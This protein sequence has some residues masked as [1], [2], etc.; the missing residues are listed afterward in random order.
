MITSDP[1]A[2]VVSAARNAQPKCVKLNGS[3]CVIAALLLAAMAARAAAS[4]PAP[5]VGDT[6]EITMIKESAQQGRNGSSGDS[7]D[8]DTIIERVIGLRADGLELEYDLPKDATADDR[9]GNWQFPARIFKPLRG[10]AQLLNSPE[11]EV[12]VDGWLKA[13]GLTRAACGHWIFTWNVFRIECD[14]QSVI[15]TVEAFDLRSADLREGAPYQD[16]GA[17]GPGTLARKATGPDGA[18][19]AVEMPVDPDAVRRVR[20][21]SDVVAGEILHKPVTLDAA[22]RAR[23]S[24]TVSGT[25]SVAFETDAAGSL[26][27]RTKVT[28]LDIK[29]PDGGSETETVTETLERRLISRRS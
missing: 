5:Q 27:R 8:K 10:P 22:L 26:R 9:A 2:D 28:K 29:D 24:E 14:P 7:H 25:I 1:I 19:F 20:A 15:K 18:T 4:P 23:A 12:R 3:M 11:L 21:E 6:Y 16:T 13:G 17:L